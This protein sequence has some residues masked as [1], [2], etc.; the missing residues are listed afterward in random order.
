[1]PD[2][3]TRAW[4]TVLERIETDLLEGRLGP[5]DRLPG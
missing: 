1:M 2:G 5:G 3:T 4:R